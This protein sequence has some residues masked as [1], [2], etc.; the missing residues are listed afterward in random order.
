MMDDSARQEQARRWGL[1]A[2]CRHARP[3]VTD[4]GAQFVQCGL[5]KDDPR[6]RRYPVVPVVWCVGFE[7]DGTGT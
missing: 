2:A 3:I 5:A 6:F 4:R 1:C 7:A